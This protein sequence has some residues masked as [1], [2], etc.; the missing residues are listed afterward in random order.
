M[1]G[2]LLFSVEAVEVM[3]CELRQD[4]RAGGLAVRQCWHLGFKMCRPVSRLPPPAG[5]S[6][7]QQLLLSSS[8]CWIAWQRA[9]PSRLVCSGPVPNPWLSR[10]PFTHVMPLVLLPSAPTLRTSSPTP[11]LALPPSLPSSRLCLPLSLSLSPLLSLLSLLQGMWGVL[12]LSLSRALSLPAFH[13]G[14]SASAP[15]PMPHPGPS[16]LTVEWGFGVFG[17]CLPPLVGLAG[18]VSV[19]RPPTLYTI[20]HPGLIPRPLR[21]YP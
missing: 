2:G 6:S 18:S 19:I 9:C 1:D 14:K 4:I 20:V 10:I 16:P 7:K 12:S 21:H 15:G 3:N 17:T 5:S 8:A 11:C 13:R